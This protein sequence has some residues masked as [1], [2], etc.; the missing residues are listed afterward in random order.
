MLGFLGKVALGGAVASC[1]VLSGCA[2]TVGSCALGAGEAVS[3][4]LGSIQTDY[5]VDTFDKG[6]EALGSLLLADPERLG[7]VLVRSDDGYSGSYRQ[8]CENATGD[9]ALFG[10]TDLDAH[11]VEVSWDLEGGAGTARM[12]LSTPDGRR[13]LAQAGL[14]GRT[15]S[16]T[17]ALPSGSNYLRL[18]TEGY[19]GLVEIEVDEVA[20]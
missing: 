10:G 20:L 15:G 2:A 12:V 4:A 19:T 14:T 5:V 11:T 13:T 3:G 7:G 18:E 6:V 9:F 8:D 1:L 16:Q 17:I